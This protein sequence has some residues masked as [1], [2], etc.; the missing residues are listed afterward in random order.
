MYF[1]YKVYLIL[2]CTNIIY[3]YKTT[4][5]QNFVQHCT[6]MDLSQFDFMFQAISSPP[7]GSV[8]VIN[9]ATKNSVPDHLVSTGK[10]I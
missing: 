7:A 4:L 2:I 3:I 6:I 5:I 10:K 8:L 1:Y 9:I